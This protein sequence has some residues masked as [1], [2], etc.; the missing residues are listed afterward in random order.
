MKLEEMLERHRV[1]VKK[2][3][4]FRYPLGPRGKMI[5][6]CIYFSFPIVGGWFLMQSIKERT[7]QKF[8]E[9]GARV[10]HATH[11]HFGIEPLYHPNAHSLQNPNRL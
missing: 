5:A 11:W 10:R 8:D 3:H 2:V 4:S 9:P 7:V 6:S 1:F